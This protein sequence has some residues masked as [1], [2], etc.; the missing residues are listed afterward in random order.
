MCRALRP[1]PEVVRAALVLPRFRYANESGRMTDSC[2]VHRRGQRRERTLLR[3]MWNTVSTH[4]AQH[5]GGATMRATVCRA[6]FANI[7]SVTRSANRIVANGQIGVP[8]DD[9]RRA[10]CWG[11]RKGRAQPPKRKP[12][13]F[14]IRWKY[15]G[16]TRHLIVPVIVGGT[17]VNDE[18]ACAMLCYNGSIGQDT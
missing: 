10:P 16:L 15:F 8:K 1:P 17:R 4:R 5:C 11:T 9:G 2:T 13:E 14:S 12:R 3:S 6:P 18:L 7:V